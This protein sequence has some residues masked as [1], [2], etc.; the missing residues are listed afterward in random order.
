MNIVGGRVEAEVGN[1][2]GDRCTFRAG[3]PS[4]AQLL[5]AKLVT[6]TDLSTV[7]TPTF[8]VATSFI[9]SQFQP[10]F[11]GKFYANLLGS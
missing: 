4:H 7:R 9:T 3:H 10:L 1:D 2:D 6:S 8:F 5:A 11:F